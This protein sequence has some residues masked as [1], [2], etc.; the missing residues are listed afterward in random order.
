MAVIFNHDIKGIIN[1]LDR[2]AMELVSSQSSGVSQLGAPDRARLEQ[3]LAALVAY[4]GWVVAA[5]GLDLPES[6]PTSYT[7][8]D[9]IG[10]SFEDLENEHVKDVVRLMGLLRVEIVKSQSSSLASGMISF[11]AS[12]FDGVV[13]KVKQFLV[14]YV[15]V[16]TPLDLPESSPKTPASN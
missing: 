6:H 2:F 4:K 9:T 12:R 10:V 8:S 15:D 1:R 3:Y 13:T 14:Q 7:V 5:P 11:D 16:A